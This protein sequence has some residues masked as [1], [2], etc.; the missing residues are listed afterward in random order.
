MALGQT[1]GGMNDQIRMQRALVSGQ[2]NSLLYSL[3][4]MLGQ[5]LQDTD[6]LTGALGVT[7]TPLQVFTQLL[8]T[9]RQFPLT[10]NR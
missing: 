4:G 10:K 1:F 2:I 7:M 5:Q 6:I 8:K 3:G 9:Q